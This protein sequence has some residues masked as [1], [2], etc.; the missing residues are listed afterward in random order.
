MYLLQLANIIICWRIFSTPLKRVEE[1]EAEDKN[2]ER[3]TYGRQEKGLET[4]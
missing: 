1:R 2:V 4:L 3:A